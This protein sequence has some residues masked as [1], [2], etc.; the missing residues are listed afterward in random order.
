MTNK[1]FVGNIDWDA[2]VDQLIAEF[3]K[4]GELETR[5][6]S[7]PNVIII[8][9]KFTGRPKGFGFVSYVSEEDAQKAMEALDGFELN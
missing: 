9:D 4:Y 8:Q 6:D 3:G 7:T 5:D 2:T 1:L